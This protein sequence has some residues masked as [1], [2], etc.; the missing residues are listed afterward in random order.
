[1]PKMTVYMREDIAEA[2]GAADPFKRAE[3]QEGSVYR[4]REGRRTLRFTIDS[5]AYFLKY[6]SGIGWKEIIK[7]F[8]Q[9]K[10]PVL[11]AM[12]EVRAV[13][14]LQEAGVATMS[15]AAYGVRGRNPARQESFIVTDELAETISLEDLGETWLRDKCS[16]SATF[17]RDLIIRVA[18]IARV[19]HDSGINHLAFY[20]AHFLLSRDC[21][22]AKAADA[23][24]Y[25]IDLHRTQVRNSV[26]RRWK[27]KDLG[28]LY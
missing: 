10:L 2:W 27:I 12:T 26:P 9:A 22:Q 7:N 28:G 13:R 16:L 20:L 15:I 25:L 8:S 6:H 24:I 19:M 18:G 17:K 4:A 1:M 11:G 23:D 5:K 14:A 21:A 3:A